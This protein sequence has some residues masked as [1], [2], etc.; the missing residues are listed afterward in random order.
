MIATTS[1]ASSDCDSGPEPTPATSELWTFCHMALIQDFEE[2][3]F[4]SAAESISNQ[5]SISLDGHSLPCIH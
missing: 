5:S 2:P 1:A 4:L 3:F